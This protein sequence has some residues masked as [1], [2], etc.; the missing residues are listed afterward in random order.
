[1]T[2]Q[3]FYDTIDTLELDQEVKVRYY[4]YNRKD[5]IDI[6]GILRDKYDRSD[7]SMYKGHWKFAL[8]N[9]MPLLIVEFI[10]IV[11]FH[12]NYKEKNYPK[13]Q[14]FFQDGKNYGSIKSSNIISIKPSSIRAHK[15]QQ[16][17][18]KKG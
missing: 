11:K 6:I 1:M 3:E 4:T 15:I 10:Q 8:K 5:Y 17:R 13:L 12:D 18:N 9:D 2:K 16:L 7:Y 14:T